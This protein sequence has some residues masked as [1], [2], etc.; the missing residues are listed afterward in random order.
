MTPSIPNEQGPVGSFKRRPSTLIEL[1]VVM[2]I[3]AVL[4]G[5]LLPA[6]QAASEGRPAGQLRQ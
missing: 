2:A 6:V 4:I 3:V 5:L 1:L